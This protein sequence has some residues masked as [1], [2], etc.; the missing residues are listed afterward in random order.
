[1][2]LENFLLCLG[3]GPPRQVRED[4]VS[5][6]PTHRH[7]RGTVCQHAGTTAAR[8][9]FPQFGTHDRLAGLS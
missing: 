4:G 5:T 8:Y 9:L 7:R 6:Y 1:M 2:D 3:N